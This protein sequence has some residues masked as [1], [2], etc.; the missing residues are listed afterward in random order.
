VA[1]KP[2]PNG[3]GFEEIAPQRGGRRSQPR[4]RP[5]ENCVPSAI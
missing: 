5:I 3:A 1:R 4:F 2:A